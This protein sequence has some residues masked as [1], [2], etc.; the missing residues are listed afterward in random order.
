MILVAVGPIPVTSLLV[1]VTK[2]MH[3]AHR[4]PDGMGQNQ[5]A[6]HWLVSDWVPILLDRSERE[7]CGGEAPWPNLLRFLSSGLVVVFL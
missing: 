2:E 6:S 3:L 1:N 7:T 5:R 4:G